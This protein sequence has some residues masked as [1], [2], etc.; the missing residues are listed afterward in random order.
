MGNPPGPVDRRA[1]D[2]RGDIATSTAPLI[3]R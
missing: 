2:E 3:G 1:I